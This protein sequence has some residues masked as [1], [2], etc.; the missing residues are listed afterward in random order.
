MSLVAWIIVGLLAGF[1]AGR[2]VNRQGQG[3]VMDNVLGVVGAVM[4]GWLF[5]KF[6]M[7]GGGVKGFDLYSL[8]VAT[9]GAVVLLMGY[10]AISGRVP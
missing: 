5:T 9:V 7:A 2:L 1:V 8:L 4:G 3:V 6:G 10:H